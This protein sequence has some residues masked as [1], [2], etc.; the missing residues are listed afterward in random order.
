MTQSLDKATNTIYVGVVCLL[1]YNILA[2]A[3]DVVI[4]NQASQ[5]NPYLMTAS[6]FLITMIFFQSSLLIKPQISGKLVRS[7]ILDYLMLNITTAIS[8]VSLYSSL[9][10]VEPA[11]VAALIGGLNPVATLFLNRILRPSSKIL[12]AEIIGSVVV[13]LVG[14][15]LT[16]I[17]LTGRSALQL[18][19][20]W[21]SIKGLIYAGIAALAFSCTTIFSKRLHDDG[22][23]TVPIMAHRFYLL[24][25]ASV[26]AAGGVS[27]V[28]IFLID[29][30]FL[31]IV[32]AFFG[33]IASLYLLQEGTRL[34][35]P[36]TVEMVVAS[37]PIFTLLIQVFDDRLIMSTHSMFANLALVT[38]VSVTVYF[39]MRESNESK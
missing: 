4:G 15:Y 1:G 9:S 2:A 37:A 30:A 34:C 17:V 3:K 33:A 38:V 32:V 19:D 5:Y 22:V 18:L 21:Q 23:G 8:W 26:W 36:M 28:L 6:I 31:M 10:L 29:N 24:L 20:T 39:Q 11:L 7:N 12:R 14:V 35:E 13:L 27:E 25:V 16:W